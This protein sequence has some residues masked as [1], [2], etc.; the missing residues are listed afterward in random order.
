[1]VNNAGACVYS[2]GRL[3]GVFITRPRHY[4]H[5]HLALLITFMTFFLRCIYILLIIPSILVAYFDGKKEQNWK[6]HLSRGHL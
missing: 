3:K 5:I 4:S 2:D 6:W 1:M